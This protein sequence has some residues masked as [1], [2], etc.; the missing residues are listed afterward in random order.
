LHQ[1]SDQT[2]CAAAGAT[3]PNAPCTSET[4]TK[5]YTCVSDTC[6]SYCETASD[7]AT[8]ARQDCVQVVRG[9]QDI[10]GFKVCRPHCDLRDPR[11]L[12]KDGSFGACGSEATCVWVQDGTDSFTSCDAA[13]PKS[14]CQSDT[15][16]APGYGCFA[17]TDACAKWCRVGVA[18]D[19]TAGQSCRVLSPKVTVQV[20]GGTR[21]YGLCAGTSAEGG[22][23]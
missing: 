8:S 1:K 6:R 15:D 4:C 23:R 17:T 3:A 22:T 18:G 5:G 12:A 2:E 13:S 11:N 16:C 7:C 10:V 14:T 19:C 9:D 21:E 20:S